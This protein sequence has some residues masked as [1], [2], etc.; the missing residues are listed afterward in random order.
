MMKLR[1]HVHILGIT[2]SIGLLIW[3]LIPIA[4]STTRANE[5]TINMAAGNELSITCETTFTADI[6]DNEGRITCATTEPTTE[7]TDTA[8]LING[9]NGVEDGGSVNGTIAIEAE[10]SGDTIAEVVFALTG[11]ESKTHTERKRPYY[12]L[13]DRDVNGTREPL[14]WDTTTY[15]DGDYQLS[16]TATDADQQSDSITVAFSVANGTNPEPTAEPTTEPTAEPTQVPAPPVGG[17]NLPA[18]AATYLGGNSD[19]EATAVDVAPNGDVLMAGVTPDYNPGNMTPTDLLGG[20]DG[21]IVR[22]DDKG[23]EVL[24]VTRIGDRVNDLEINNDGRIAACGNFGVATLN[25][26]A[27][28]VL[29]NADTDGAKRCSIGADGTVAAI[30]GGQAQVYNNNGDR[31]ASWAIGGSNQ[32]D[33]VVDSANQLIIATGFTNR[34][35]GGNPVQVAFMRAWSYGGAAAWTSYDFSGAEAARTSLMADTRGY[36]VTIGGDGNLYLAAE[37]AGGNTI[38]T[39]D[40]DSINEKVGDRQVKTDNYTNPFNTRSNHITWYGRYNPANGELEQGQIVLTRLSSGAGNTIRP[41][42]IDAD[43]NGTV[44][45]SGVSACC[46]ADRDNQQLGGQAIGSYS[47]GESF[48]LVVSPNLAE[49]LYW[50]PFPGGG[51]ASVAVRNGQAAFATTAS[52]DKLVTL[53]AI[54]DTPGNLSDAYLTVVK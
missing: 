45:V 26:T 3:L 42:G 37:S 19:D 34:R 35:G 46:I 29:W 18:S 43:A 32:E 2:L 28:E 27:N 36:R 31:V 47:G 38:F 52:E 40:P 23:Q 49:R 24:S 51:D 48:L 11:P 54:Q 22:I 9:L 44:Y 17:N 4:T 7:S 53:N 25:A 39:R 1:Q 21:S 6:Q 12:F 15:P 8:S 50:T 13:G 14:G 5:Q 33:I 16:V 30:V 20:G 41:R 10:V